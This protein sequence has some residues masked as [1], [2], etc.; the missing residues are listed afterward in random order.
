MSAQP[1]AHAQ[2]Q[3]AQHVLLAAEIKIKGALADRGLRRDGAD[4]GIG[5]AFAADFVLRGV[6]DLLPRAL[7]AAR[8]GR[9]QRRLGI[10]I[11]HE[12]FVTL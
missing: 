10:G 4:G 6:E 1:P 12:A 3:F 2:H 11:G 7:A 9:G 8:F 5:K